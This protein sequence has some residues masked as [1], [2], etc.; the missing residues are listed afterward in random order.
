MANAE[1]ACAYA[2]LALHD[3]GLVVTA[4]AIIEMT[5]TAGIEI[6]G[7]FWPI[8]FERVGKTMND[9][10]NLIANAVPSISL[11]YY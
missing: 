7:S 11:I 5:K 6:D 4:E 1:L 2:A 9:L 10:D 8:F 3:A